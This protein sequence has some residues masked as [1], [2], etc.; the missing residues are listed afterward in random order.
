MTS[1]AL[2]DVENIP[3]SNI[4]R[5]LS[6]SEDPKTN[7]AALRERLH[8]IQRKEGSWSPPGDKEE[9]INDEERKRLIASVRENSTHPAPWRAL[10]QYEQDH[11][12]HQADEDPK[13]AMLQ[14]YAKA[15][16]CIPKE[17]YRKDPDYVAI[18]LGFVQLQMWYFIHTVH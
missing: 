2:D 1:V 9:A 17:K 14:L 12:T 6:S 3:P 5:R 13:R 15:T 18:W 10:L 16:R 8:Q 11:P 4:Q 7:L